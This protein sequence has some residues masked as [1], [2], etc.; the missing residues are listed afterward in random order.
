MEVSGAGARAGGFDA[1]GGES[2]K[3]T[4]SAQASSG[5]S[6]ETAWGG[7]GGATVRMGGTGP[8]DGA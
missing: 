6:G 4:A 1:P 8:P 5:C 2:S 7:W 3:G